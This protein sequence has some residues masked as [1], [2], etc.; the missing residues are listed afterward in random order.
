[1]D[2]HVRIYEDVLELN[3]CNHLINKFEKYID[4]HESQKEGEMSFTQ[5]DMGKHIAVWHSEIDV[6]RKVLMI[7]VTKYANDLEIGSVWPTKHTF[8]SPRIKRYLPNDQDQFGTH[9]DVNNYENSKRFLV[10]FI[11]LDD[12]EAG[13]TIISPG[14]KEHYRR[15]SYCKRGNMLI[16]P[17]LWPWPHSGE[18][19]IKKPKYI[20]GSYLHYV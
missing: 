13:Q 3:Y 15:I 2:N 8:E 14:G 9:V 6:L 17:P 12:N 18:K 20:I 5:I 19:P 1:M 10:F 7:N 11:Y 16:F 4:Q